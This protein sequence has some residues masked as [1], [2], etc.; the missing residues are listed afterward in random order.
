MDTKFLL[1]YFWFSLSYSTLAFASFFVVYLITPQ[2]IQPSSLNLISYKALPS[3]HYRISDE[4]KFNDGRARIV[5]DFFKKYKSVLAS[6]ADLF[7]KVA[8]EK[9]LDW[10]LMPAISMQESNGGKKVINDSHNPFGYGIWGQ[11][12]TKFSSWE[13]GIETVAGGLKANYYDKGLKTPDA[14]MP[15]YT[16]PSLARGGT[17]AKGVKSF[18]AEL[19]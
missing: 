13:E 1:V 8:D 2:Y 18:M 4:V 9:Q 7:V 11:K 14:I 19:R 5:E 15:K 6:Q 12:V 3:I 17:W 10:R 16:P